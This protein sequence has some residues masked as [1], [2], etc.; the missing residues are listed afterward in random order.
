MSTRIS[1]AGL[2]H[3][4][5]GKLDAKRCT[6][7]FSGALGADR[8]AVQFN[9]MLYDGQAQT[10]PAMPPCRRC[11]RLDKPVKQIGQEF[12]LN[13]LTIVDDARL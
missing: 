10:Q 9:Q 12:R 2:M 1:L 4:H 8:P 3:N 5:Q 11:I 13:A 6:V 7:A